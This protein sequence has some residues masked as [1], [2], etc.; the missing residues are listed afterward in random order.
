MPA[1]RLFS[2]RIMLIDK[3]KN[4]EFASTIRNINKMIKKG[5]IPNPIMN[6]YSVNS[7][8]LKPE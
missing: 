4:Q 5:I 6:P 8:R 7:K 1:F 2:F 3:I